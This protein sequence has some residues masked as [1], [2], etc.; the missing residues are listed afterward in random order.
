MFEDHQ[1]FR[2]DRGIP[3]MVWIE[4]QAVDFRVDPGEELRVVGVSDQA[5]CF[6]VVDYGERIGVYSW[7]GASV[8]V[9]QHDQ[10]LDDIPVWSHEPPPGEG[11]IRQFIEAMFGGPG[12]PYDRQSA[13]TTTAKQHIWRRCFDWLRGSA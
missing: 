9:Y 6:E 2:N 12:G 3:Y 1:T 10:L 4:P 5:G 13:A 8:Q 11:S 7:V